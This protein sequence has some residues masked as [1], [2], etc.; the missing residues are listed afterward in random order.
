MEHSKKYIAQHPHLPFLT[1][2]NRSYLVVGYYPK[3]ALE[4]FLPQAISIPSDTVMAEKYPTVMQVDGMHPFML[5]FANCHN[6]HDLMSEYELRP[7]EEIQ[8]CF[9]ATYTHEGGEQQH[10]LFVKL[11]Y[12]EYLLGVLGGMYFGLRKQFRPSMQVVE[13]A[14]SRSWVIP[15]I[16][17]AGFEQT[18][19]ESGTELDPFFAQMFINP[20]VTLSYFNQYRFYKQR[21]YPKKVLDASPAYEWHYKDSVIKNN[22]N[23]FATYSEYHFSISQVMKYGAYFHPASAVGID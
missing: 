18:A 1:G 13:T 2:N 12:L 7:Y 21:V 10:C 11:M 4:K 16:I 8:A 23:T 17:D 22:E 6:V 15:G 14:T 19:T 20:A 9:P 3:E 5:Q